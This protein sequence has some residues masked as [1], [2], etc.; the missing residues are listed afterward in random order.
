[1]FF[2]FNPMSPT[3]NELLQTII[4]QQQIFA[5]VFNFIGGIILYIAIKR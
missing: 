5:L 4:L 1:M 3:T 2:R